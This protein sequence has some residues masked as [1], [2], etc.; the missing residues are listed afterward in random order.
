LQAAF[1][2]FDKNADGFISLN[3]VIDVLGNGST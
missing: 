3:E 1:R 2:V